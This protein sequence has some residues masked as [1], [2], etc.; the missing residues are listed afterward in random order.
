M[1]IKAAFEAAVSNIARYGDTDAFPSPFANDVLF[2]KPSEVVGL[3]EKIYADI[4]L[5]LSQ[6]SPL[7]SDT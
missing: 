3:L 7:N 6:Y 1:H 2:D 5:A 4:D